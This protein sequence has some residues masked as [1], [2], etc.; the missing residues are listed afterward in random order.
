MKQKIKKSLKFLIFFVIGILIFWI[1]YKDQD[2]DRIK[3]ILTSDVNY[4]WIW[5]SIFIGFLSHISRAI[6]WRYLIEPMGHMPRLVNT[7]F[8][9]MIG[10][11]MNLVIPR[12]GELSK[13]GVLARYEKI[14]FARL[15]GTMIT[16][17]IFDLL[18]LGFFTLLMVFTQFG[19][20]IRFLKQNPEVESKLISLITSPLLIGTGVLMIILLVL[21]WNK[22]RRSKIFRKIEYT[23]NHFKEGI[24]SFRF[25]RNKWAF[26]FHTIFI[27][28][29]YFMM[30]YV[31]FFA[32]DFTS[33]L[34]P[35][36]GLTTFVMASFGMVA[37]V[38][39]GIGAWHFMTRESLALY[40][41]PYDDGIIF[42]FLAHGIMTLMIIVLG[43]FSFLA[44]PFVNR[45]NSEEIPEI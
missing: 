25:I 38:Q 28:S 30:L 9:V 26:L 10:Y 17:R 34:S 32:F 31:S 5:I 36:A 1:I 37:P 12:M 43:L 44:L 35:L 11:I 40:G 27:W 3:S 21:F 24:L 19:Q 33:G 16:E 14:S 42:A 18:A 4:F 6:R 20:V 22:I 45:R 2:I 23:A 39:G 15:I 7:F 41:V 8:A 13:C 29:M